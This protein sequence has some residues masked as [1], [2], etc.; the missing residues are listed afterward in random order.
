VRLVVT[1][2]T[3]LGAR[4]RG[5]L[6]APLLAACRGAD[7]ILHTGDLTEPAVLDELE[8]YAP[9][10]AVL[11]NVDGWDLVDRLPERRVVEAGPVR[12][13][14]IHDPGQATGR[15]ARLRAAFPGCRVV[16]FGHSHLPV[17]ARDHDLLLLNPGSPTERRRAPFHSYA[18]LT[19]Q[20]D[21]AVDARIVPIEKDP[22]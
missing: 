2:D 5:P 15:A 10:A 8:A 13:G 18:E 1:G 6:P 22:R 11:G 14:M 20:G 16:V 3:H 17:C 7:L 9:V 21:G 19:I 4:R 12:I